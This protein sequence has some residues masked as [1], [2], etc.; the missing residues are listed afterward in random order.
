MTALGN[1][2]AGQR[3]TAAEVQGVAPLAAWKAADQSVTSSTTL[4]NDT[5]LFLSLAANATYKFDL[6]LLY[7]G[8]A[9]GTA[10]LKPAWTV[11]SGC[12]IAAITGGVNTGLGSVWGTMTQSTVNPAAF[13]TNGTSLPLS[14]IVS[15]TVTTSSTPGIMQF[16]WAQNTS[17]ATPTTV[18]AG[19][20]L[21]A[22]QIA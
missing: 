17:N 20:S 19:S 12:V 18:M 7:K 14:L 10:D 6:A 11:P 2:L 8:A 1:L 16:Q 13:G 9:T 5:A 4:V 3:L 22:W 21:A 15:G